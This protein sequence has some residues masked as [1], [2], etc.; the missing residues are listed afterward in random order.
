MIGVTIVVSGLVYWGLERFN[1][2][3]DDKELENDPIQILFLAAISFTGH[4]E[5]R[6]FTNAARLF[7]FSLAFWS[8]L[9]ASA[10]TANLASFL[11]VQ[12][13]PSLQ[14]NAVGDA[15]QANLP[16]CVVGSSNADE[17]VSSV[18]PGAKLIRKKEEKDIYL[19]VT[20]GECVVAITTVN[21]WEL[22]EGDRSVNGDCKMGWIGRVFKFVPAGFTTISDSGT[23]CTSLIRDV[24]NLHLLE[25]KE[26][27]F[28][29]RA[30][31]KHLEQ[32]AD[33]NCNA[34]SVDLKDNESDQLSLK[35]M[36]SLFIFHFGLTAV[37]I[38]MAVIGKK[39]GE[40]K[41]D[42]ATLPAGNRKLSS[43]NNP[44]LRCASSNQAA[45]SN[46]GFAEN[47]STDDAVVGGDLQAQFESMYQ[48]QTEQMAAIL[49]MSKTMQSDFDAMR[50]RIQQSETAP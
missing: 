29:D 12:N 23:L 48:K 6:P 44:E 17:A 39:Y 20:A 5:F 18:Y 42:H 25:M 9:V 43:R 10:Y 27:G 49:A 28:V 11:V 30:W 35:D 41:R 34:Q 50:E 45:G 36:G 1:T 26:D 3:T 37:A 16:M 38:C 47:G 46:D 24:L 21:S 32:N 8:L 31:H 14:L 2:K 40:W 7:T 22:Y 19:G 4:F 13:T 15:V 33:I